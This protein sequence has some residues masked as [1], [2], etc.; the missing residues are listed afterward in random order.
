[1]YTI[2]KVTVTPSLPCSKSFLAR[3]LGKKRSK[4]DDGSCIVLR[5][6]IILRFR[7]HTELG[8][9]VMK[10]YYNAVCPQ[11]RLSIS[12][13]IQGVVIITY[14]NPCVVVF[15]VSGLQSEAAIALANCDKIARRKFLIQRQ[16]ELANQESQLELLLGKKIPRD[17]GG[18]FKQES[19]CDLNTS[20]LQVI[21]NDLHSK[22]ERLNEQLMHL[23]IEKDELQ[24]RGALCTI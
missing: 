18:K 13:I 10:N 22:I 4:R 8:A 5:P 7:R 20:T 14:C 21:V 16:Q 2:R 15:V 12:A 23:V 17:A 9:R 6:S 24:V 1:M 3:E 11:Q 19:L